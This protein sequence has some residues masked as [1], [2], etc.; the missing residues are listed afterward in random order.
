MI[1]RTIWREFERLLFARGK[2][3]E[4]FASSAMSGIGCDLLV[5]PHILTLPH[6][7]G[8]YD[9]GLRGSDLGTLM[10]AFGLVWLAAL[11]VNGRRERGSS[12]LRMICAAFGCII[13]GA[14]A[15]SSWA[16]EVAPPQ[17]LY[18]LL[19]AFTGVACWRS[20]LDVFDR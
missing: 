3:F 7:M 20:S 4:W 9:L 6:Y 11:I 8:L 14:F 18:S 1:W 16:A 17:I 2:L 10:A 19:T 12:L 15:G 13:F 5:H